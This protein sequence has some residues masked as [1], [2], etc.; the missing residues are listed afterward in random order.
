MAVKEMIN[1]KYEIDKTF[2]KKQGLRMIFLKRSEGQVV[3]IKKKMPMQ[4]TLKRGTITGS[5]RK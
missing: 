3:R 5:K 2:L 1:I 4:K